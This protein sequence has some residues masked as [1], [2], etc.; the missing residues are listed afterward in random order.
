MVLALPAWGKIGHEAL[1]DLYAEEFGWQCCIVCDRI[2]DTA[3]QQQRKGFWKGR[4]RTEEQ[5]M[6][7]LMEHSR[8]DPLG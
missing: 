4:A 3:M 2:D 5:I 8:Y 1:F 7:Q 6:R